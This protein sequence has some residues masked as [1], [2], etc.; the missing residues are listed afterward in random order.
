MRRKRRLVVAHLMWSMET[1]MIKFDAR[2]D[3]GSPVV[4]LHSGGMSGRQWRRLADKLLA[5]HRVVAPDFLGSGDNPPWPEG[6]PFEFRQDV[7][8]VRA[9]LDTLTVPYHLVGHSYGGLVAATIARQ[10]P[11]AVRSIALYDPVCFGVLHDP[12]DDA[13]LADLARASEDPV[14]LDDARGGSAEWFEAFVDYWN[15]AG[16]WKA[17]PPPA[18][19]GFLKVGRKVYAEVRSLVADRTTAAEYAVIRAPALL[20]TGERSPAAAGRVVAR[21]A[22]AMPSAKIIAV[23]GAGHMGPLTHGVEVNDAIA[24]HIASVDHGERE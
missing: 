16:A 6:A 14:F 22:S 23:M 13:G 24:S 21:L 19:A 3:N 9:V 17:M 12:P 1:T 10:R 5:E 20:L 4:M 11:E 2:G 15:G 7:E 18:Q 8:A